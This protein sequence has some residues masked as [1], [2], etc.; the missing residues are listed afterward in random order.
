[1][2]NTIVVRDWTGKIIGKIETDAQGNK[3]VRDFYE[4]Y[5]EDMMQDVMLRET[6]M[7]G[8]LL[9]EIHQLCC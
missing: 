8:A 1:M 3:T 9:K 4:E 5:L 2:S 6:F 7:V